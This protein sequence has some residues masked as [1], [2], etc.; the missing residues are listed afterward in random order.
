MSFTLQANGAT[1][2]MTFYTRQSGTQRAAPARQGSSS[3]QTHQSTTSVMVVE[4]GENGAIKRRFEG[5][6]ATTR[7]R[8]DLGAKYRP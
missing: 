1:R 2:K 5:W 7:K 8:H 6:A 4:R 3:T